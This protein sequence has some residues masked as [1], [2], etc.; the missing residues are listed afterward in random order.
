MAMSRERLRSIVQIQTAADV[1]WRERLRSRRLHKQQQHWR[2]G[3][4][5]TYCVFDEVNKEL[6]ISLEHGRTPVV[7]T[8]DDLKL[9]GGIR[10]QGGPT[11]VFIGDGLTLNPESTLPSTIITPIP[12]FIPSPSPLDGILGAITSILGAL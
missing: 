1:G 11:S 12:T 7:F 9:P 2:Y 3:G 4:I 6:Q 5:T 8:K 10:I